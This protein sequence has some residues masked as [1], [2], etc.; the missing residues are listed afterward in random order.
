V[1]LTATA[2][3]FS[4]LIYGSI[5]VLATVTQF[6]LLSVMAVMEAL[7]LSST[8]EHRGRLEDAGNEANALA[9]VDALTGMPNRR[10]FDEALTHAIDDAERDG[11][12][13]ALLL[14]D[15]D[16]FKQINDS[17]GH[18]AG[19]QVL[20]AIANTLTQAMRR[21]DTAYRWAGDEFAVLLRDSDEASASR[22]AGRLRKAVIRSCRRPDGGKVTL[23]TGVAALKPGMSVEEVLVEADR[24][25]LFQKA[26]R[27]QMR[28]A[29]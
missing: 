2:A 13:M 28:G 5:D 26:R 16:S 3:A 6:T 9:H 21:P 7:V 10:A 27:T 15:V 11:T 20:Q 12:A 8:R 4:R 29:A 17:F 18:T 22:V 19:D 24:T 1:A 23:G 25:L 14:C